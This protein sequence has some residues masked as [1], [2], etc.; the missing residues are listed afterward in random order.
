MAFKV[1]EKGSAPIPSVPSV[2][3]QKRGLMSINRAAYEMLGAPAGVELLWDSERRVIGLRAAS[4]DSPNAYPARPQSPNSAKGPMLIAGSL[5]TR[6]VG[7]DTT[8]AYRW[9]PFMEEDVLCIDLN[10][11]GQKVLSN[12]A[13]AARREAEEGAT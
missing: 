12:R 1:F 9:V 7:L 8:D 5:F 6:F 2:T 11:P 4:I 3:I 13:K 10:K